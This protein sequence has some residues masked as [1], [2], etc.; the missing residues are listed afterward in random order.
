[1]LEVA[2]HSD[3]DVRGSLFLDARRMRGLTHIVP[4][5]ISLTQRSRPERNRVERFIEQT[6]ARCYGSVISR[7]YPMLMSVQDGD[8]GIVAAVG[9]RE[10]AEETLFLEQY[11]REPVEAAL[12]RAAGIDVERERIVEIGNLAASGKGASVFLFVTLAAYLRQRDVAYAVVTATD[13]LRQVFDFFHFAPLEL[14]AADPH[15]LPDDGASWGNYYA[16]DP[17]V[18][19]G[20]VAPCFLRLERYLPAGHNADLGRLFARIYPTIDE[21]SP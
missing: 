8:S 12:R 13:V 7:H 11:L 10:A 1:V 20:A 2:F 15:A 14:A 4:S 9:L 17:K 21:P 6:Y 3:T 18:L 5:I 19:A 16:R